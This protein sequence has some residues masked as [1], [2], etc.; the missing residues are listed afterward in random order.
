MSLNLEV[1]IQV[2]DEGS[3]CRY[4]MVTLKYNV[5]EGLSINLVIGGMFCSHMD[6]NIFCHKDF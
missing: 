3:C 1:E 4:Y 6:L 2:V 5:V